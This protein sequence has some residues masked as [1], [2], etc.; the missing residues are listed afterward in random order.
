MYSD[1][2]VV[3]TMCGGRFRMAVRSLCGVSPVRTNVRMSTSGKP[4]AC[5]S[6]R[7][8]ASGASRLRRMSFERALSGET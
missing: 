2:G 7:M 8:P 6:V 1:S 3:T 4:R 5:N